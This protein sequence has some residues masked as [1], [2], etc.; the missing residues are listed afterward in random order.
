MFGLEFMRFVSACFIC[1]GAC[2]FIYLPVIDVWVI[3]V[4]G[5][6]LCTGLS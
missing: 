3:D 6:F 5:A 4:C 1:V 2:C